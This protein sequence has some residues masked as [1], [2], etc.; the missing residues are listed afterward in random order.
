[1]LKTKASIEGRAELRQGE[2]VSLNL[3]D[4]DVTELEKRVELSI[5]LTA[6]Y[7]WAYCGPWC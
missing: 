6:S 3:A 4:L 1:V 7:C 2:L 5:A